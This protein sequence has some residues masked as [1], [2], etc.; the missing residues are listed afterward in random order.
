MESSN[1]VP[2]SFGF[3]NLLAL[4]VVAEEKR[5][6]KPRRWM[7]RADIWFHSWN[8]TQAIM[9]DMI[10]KL[11]RYTICK[12]IYLISFGVLVLFLFFLFHNTSFLSF[13]L[14]VYRRCVEHSEL[15]HSGTFFF[16][17]VAFWY[18]LLLLS[19]HRKYLILFSNITSNPFIAT[20]SFRLLSLPTCNLSKNGFFSQTSFETKERRILFLFWEIALILRIIL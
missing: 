19:F 9:Y 3:W 1:A 17:R 16:Q 20:G 2:S 5:G 12:T 15:W 14:S 13:S 4:A 11:R 7:I 8:P 10:K 18:L 6:H